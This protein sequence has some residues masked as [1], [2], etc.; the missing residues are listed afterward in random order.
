[1]PKSPPSLFGKRR[2]SDDQL[3]RG[4]L[5]AAPSSPGQMDLEETKAGMRPAWQNSRPNPYA[6]LNDIVLEQAGE[7]DAE[8][9]NLS[10]FT[11]EGKAAAPKVANVLNRLVKFPG[12][13]NPGGEEALSAQE[14]M[15]ALLAKAPVKLGTMAGVYL[16]TIQNIFGVILFLR[17]PWIVG[18][19]GVGQALLIVA[20]CCTTTMLTALSLSAIATN[21]VVP[22]GGAYF[23]ISRNLGPEFGGAVG[24]LFYLGTTFAGA[25]YILGAIELLLVYIAPQMSAF[26]D[27]DPGS[28][29][30]LDNLRLYGSVVLSVLA[31]VVFVGVKYVNRF[32]GVCLFAVILSIFCIF[33]GFFTTPFA[34]QPY[35]CQA[36]QGLM[37]SDDAGNCTEA[38]LQATY[39]W[40]TN[41]TNATRIPGF[42]GLDSGVGKYNAHSTYLGQGEIAHGI[43]GNEGQV[44][45]TSPT[46]SF[47]ILLAIFFPSVT[48]I[49]AGSNRSG[50]LKD[51]SASIPKGTIAA[52]LTTSTVYFLAVIL[53]GATTE[54]EVLRDKFGESIGGRLVLAQL[55]WP[56]EWIVLIGA[57]LSCI[58]AALQSL[59]GAPRLLQAIAQDD[60]IKAL[61]FFGKASDSGEPTRALVLTVL[62]AEAGILIASLDAV[63]PIITMF[64][65]MCY[66]FVNLACAIQSLL[67]SPSWRPR[68]KY[69]H[70][71]LSA[72]GVVLC[73][74]LMLVSSWVY[75]IVAMITAGCIYYY[76]QY[77]GAAK[78]WGDGLRGLSMQAAKF[79]LLRLEDTPPHTKNWR[80]QVLTFARLEE[81]ENGGARL[82]EPSLIHL[83]AQLKG[84][85]GL[86]M[87]ASVITGRY[88]D[89][90][91]HAAEGQKALKR[92]LLK[93][94]T[95]GFAQVMVGPDVESTISH[96][97][98][99]SGLGALRHNTVILGWPHRWRTQP[100]ASILL[101]AMSVSRA[102]SLA[103]MVPK[104]ESATPSAADPATQS[105]DVWWIM[106]DGGMLILIAFLLR[107]DKAWSRCKLRIFCVAESDDNSIQ[108]EQDL[109]LFVRLLRIDAEVFVVEMVN[110]DITPHTISRAR[111]LQEVLA[112]TKRQPV[113]S[114]NETTLRR[115][116]TAT[117]M[118]AVLTE[119][120]K[121]ADL[122]ALCLPD[123]I[124]NDDPF[125][126]MTL[127]EELTAGLNRVLFIRGGGREVITIFS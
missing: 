80:P 76:I 3:N 83:A 109:A 8:T 20:I 114:P 37:N 104:Y 9:D 48:G 77:R 79:S 57:L 59:T 49:M 72:V 21:G 84:G 19:A 23:M 91:E 118:N 54:G 1:M 11:A 58:G 32:A 29:A 122:V 53:L 35:V 42:P 12:G 88:Q 28:D 51:P 66:A 60:L 39:D 25:M 110:T 52:I 125:V 7:Y 70:W 45:E 63:A 38:Y 10:L 75:A 50:D 96:L 99:G 93:A 56:S 115:M 117:K 30:F 87:V 5:N 71:S 15:L 67:K 127:L 68:Y 24:I 64:F 27:V 111:E 26:G 126:Y 55:S 17:M 86:T 90:H 113:T 82:L 89:R 106:H 112:N 97:I 14:S 61:E 73:I 78:E 95:E 46:T 31:F 92:A 40:F 123:P 16:P 47:A 101:E 103:F 2:G 36:G 120:S 43:D 65:L 69:Y 100:S 108:M 105:I 18:I 107:Q 41:T 102:A 4:L 94:S 98:Q 121:N 62:I 44:V 13:E 34:G 74:L 116:N 119:R 124:E 81:T 22:A 33:I 85:K 6:T